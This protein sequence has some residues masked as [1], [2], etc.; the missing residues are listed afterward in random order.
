LAS[1]RSSKAATRPS[2]WAIR[3]V[4]R[5]EDGI[6][7]GNEALEP[8]KRPAEQLLLAALRSIVPRPVYEDENHLGWFREVADREIFERRAAAR[9]TAPS[10]PASTRELTV[11]RR[12]LEAAK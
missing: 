3:K 12:S 8:R 6:V 10:S 2:L 1:R 11:L 5:K 7:V 4:R 9:E